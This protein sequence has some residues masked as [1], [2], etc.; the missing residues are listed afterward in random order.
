LFKNP[1]LIYS[2]TLQ[3]LQI[4]GNKYTQV[5]I[6]NLHTKSNATQADNNYQIINLSV[7]AIIR[8]NAS[9]LRQS[10][11]VGPIVPPWKIGPND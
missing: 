7:T 3:L 4:H 1:W 9:T 11:W 5:H 2:Q 10:A 8:G 6:Q